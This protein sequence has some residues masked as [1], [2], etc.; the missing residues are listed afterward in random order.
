MACN[1]SL[2]ASYRGSTPNGSTCVTRGV[3]FQTTGTGGGMTINVSPDADNDV[4]LEVFTGSCGSLS[5]VVCEDSGIE[6]EDDTYSFLT[7]SGETY[8]IYAGES[9]FLDDNEG[10]LT[11]SLTCNALLPVAAASGCDNTVN[12][13]TMTG[14]GE[15]LPIILNSSIVGKIKDTEALGLTTI[16]L[17][18]NTGALRTSGGTPLADRNIT[19]NPANAPSLTIPVRLFFTAAEINALIAADP[20]VSSIADLEFTKVSGTSC[21]GPYPGGGVQLVT[22]A[23]GSYGGEYFV[24]TSVAAFSEFFLSSASAPLPVELASFTAVAKTGATHVKWETASERNVDYFRIERS[25][26]G[27]DFIEIGEVAAVGE[28]FSLQSYE[29]TD[30]DPLPKGYYRLVSVDL[31]GS[32]STSDLVFVEQV[33]A[34][35]LEISVFPNPTTDVLNVRVSVTATVQ[36][37]DPTGRIVAEHADQDGTVQFETASMPKGL[38]YVRLLSGATTETAPVVLK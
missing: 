12:D 29:F 11:L 3:W 5:S 18:G 34:K 17:Y 8:Y 37:I 31:D 6:G 26:N 28:S 4:A 13:V 14:S 20:T 33:L 30:Y 35:A 10:S 25:S 24:Q 23:H 9:S 2:V 15:W 19:I 21:S 38:Y 7:L 1:A 32:T 27:S 16:S 22:T 36:L